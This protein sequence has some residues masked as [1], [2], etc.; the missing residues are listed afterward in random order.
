MREK[1]HEAVIA[2]FAVDVK[3]WPS[4]ASVQIM[5]VFESTVLLSSVH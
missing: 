1:R 2:V 4:S 3:K 5:Y